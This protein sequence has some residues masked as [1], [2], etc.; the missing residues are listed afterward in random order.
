MEK[1]ERV[2][3]GIAVVE[4]EEC[5]REGQRTATKEKRRRR[6]NHTMHNGEIISEKK[7]KPVRDF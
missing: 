1:E 3:P 7:K 6:K 4:R 5:A 2:A